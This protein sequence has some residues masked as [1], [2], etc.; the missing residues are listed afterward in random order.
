M[1]PKVVY[2]VR[3][4]APDDVSAQLGTDDALLAKLLWHRG[5]TTPE[6]VAAF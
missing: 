1:A 5:L 4:D 6:D 2:K 3:E